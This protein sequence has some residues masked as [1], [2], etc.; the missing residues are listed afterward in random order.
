MSDFNGQFQAAISGGP[1]VLLNQ[2]GIPQKLVFISG[3][4]KKTLCM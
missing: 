1:C 2:P 4:A 3:S